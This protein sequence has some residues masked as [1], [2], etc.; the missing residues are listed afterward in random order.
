MN[1]HRIGVWFQRLAVLCAPSGMALGAY[2]GSAKQV[3]L[4]PVH[5][6]LLLIGWVGFF[7]VGQ[8]YRTIGNRFARLAFLHLAGAVGGLALMIPGLWLMLGGMAAAESVV[9]VGS[10][11]ILMAFAIFAAIVFA[12]TRASGERQP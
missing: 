3:H 5:A 2:L 1:T 11:A 10:T 12:E 7:M 8:Y 4:A 9:I 6:H